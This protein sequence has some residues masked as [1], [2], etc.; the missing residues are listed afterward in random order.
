MLPERTLLVEGFVTGATRK[1]VNSPIMR[2][3]S[4]GTTKEPL[5]GRTEAML[6]APLMG[7]QRMLLRK[8]F[9]AVRTRE[10]VQAGIVVLKSKSVGKEFITR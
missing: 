8:N 2:F 9:A 7:V 1:G 6:S 5:T 10:R 4:P 3:K